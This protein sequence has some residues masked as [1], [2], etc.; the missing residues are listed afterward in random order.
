MPDTLTYVCPDFVGVKTGIRP[1]ARCHQPLQHG[2]RCLNCRSQQPASETIS[3]SEFRTIVQTHLRIISID[4]VDDMLSHDR[5]ASIKLYAGLHLPGLT[6]PGAWG[7]RQR[8]NDGMAGLPTAL[9]LALP[10][11]APFWPWND[12]SVLVFGPSGLWIIDEPVPIFCSVVVRLRAP[13]A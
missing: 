1:Y 5:H 11:L 13:P 7:R 6:T 4:R 9:A 8:G 10:L 2:P 3:Q 12:R